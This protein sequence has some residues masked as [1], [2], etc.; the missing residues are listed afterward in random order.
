MSRKTNF[1]DDQPL[2]ICPRTDF[3]PS[4][5][6]SKNNELYLTREEDGE[7]SL[8]KLSLQFDSVTGRF[9]GTH[10][11]A[12][13]GFYPDMIDLS[14]DNQFLLMSEIN[15]QEYRFTLSRLNLENRSC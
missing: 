12:I 6:W 13:A 7:R 5:G 3:P 15:H 11:Q 1:V 9:T 2:I 4:V 8:I 10:E 14:A